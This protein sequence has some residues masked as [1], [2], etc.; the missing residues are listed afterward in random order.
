VPRR[1]RRA[2]QALTLASILIAGV[3]CAPEPRRVASGPGPELRWYRALAVEAAGGDTPAMLA[4]PGGGLWVA[5]PGLPDPGGRSRLFHR[6][7]GGAFR[8]L[9]EG[10]FATELSLSSV[11]AGEVYF[12]SNRPLEAFRPTL[13]RVS[14]EGVTALPAP[15]ERLDALEFLQIGGYAMRSASDGMACGQRGR[16]FRFTGEGWSPTTGGLPWAPGDPAARSFCRSIQRDA[17]GHGLLVDG[18][19]QGAAWD[20]AAFQPVP[21]SEGF[22]FLEPASGIA[23]RGASLS[24]FEGGAFV[25]LDGEVPAG[26]PLIGDPTGR[27]VAHPGGVLEVGPRA[28]R[29]LPG[30]LPFSPRALAEADG[31]LWALGADGVYRATRRD[32]PTFA[33]AGPEAPAPGLLYALAVDLDQD[34]DEDLLGLRAPAGESQGARASLVVALNDGAG[35]FVEASLGLPDD[36][37]L[38]GDRFDAGDVDGDGD[39]DVVTVSSGGRVELWLQDGGRF[40]RAWW[41]DAPGATV[42]LADVDGDGDLDLSLLPATPGLWLNDGAGHFSE[43]PPLPLPAAPVERALWADVDGDGAVDAVLQHWR[44][45]AHLLHNTGHGFEL[46]PLPVV[47]EGALVADLDREGRPAILAQKIHV[48]GV[49]LPFARCRCAAEGCVAVDG[50]PVPA[51]VVVDL[52]LDGRPD[53]IVTDLRGDEA[54]ASDGEVYLAGDDGYERVTDVAG[55]MPR[56]TPIDADGDGDPDVYSPALGLRLNTGAAPRFLRVRPRTS[57]SDRLARG[58][59]AVARR[60]GSAVLVSSG[61]ADH[62]VVTLGLPEADARYDLEVRFPAG[63][64]RTVTGL[65]AGTELTVRDHEGAVFAGRL[66]LLWV[67][68]TWLRA[69]P[70]RDL[71]VPVA[72]ALI[73]AA[74]P[75]RK[76]RRG[77]VLLGFG[78]AWLSLAGTFLRAPGAAPWLLTPAAVVLT[79]AGQALLAL[80]ARRR[81]VRVAGPYRLEERL[82]AGAAATVWRARAGRQVVA[83]KLFTAEAME[84]PEA[85]ERFFREARVGS[86]I[87]HPNVVRIREAGALEDGRCFLAM[88]LVPGRSLAERIRAEGPLPAAVVRAL[89]VDVARGLGALHGADIVHRDVKPENILVRPDGVAVLSDLGLARSSLFRTLTRHDVA[90]GTLSYMSPEQCVGRPLDGRSD[91][92]SLGVT[93]YQALTGRRAFDGKHELE[94]VYLV[95]NVDPPRPSAVVPGVPPALEAAILRCLSREPGDRFATARDL[96]AALEA[97]A[98]PSDPVDHA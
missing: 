85:R 75:P 21:R 1:S 9:Y 6:P 90:V 80:R 25:P 33:A 3:G 26:A 84:S 92:W 22:A 53:V 91:L 8:T 5:V 17:E 42:A 55:A 48:R 28:A 57:R 47:A 7:P 83:L 89:G 19:G 35:R 18:A 67:R 43:G 82:G 94:L 39:V 15:E 46:L 52:N 76:R 34:G 97:S 2:G 27:W 96:E 86:E 74:V 65:A 41:R 98:A 73:F 81:A 93:L 36:V 32:V 72:A 14:A 62:G 11:R 16:L 95:H 71:L 30:G 4:D 64:R 13:L 29:P 63:E 49:A 88:E 37:A 61:R 77:A 58:A 23:R 44:D 24:R 59:F 50:A 51:G 10:P 70:V 56:P 54:M 20:G 12:G 38:W 60:A 78:A 68:G 40:R 31:A 45:P 69:R 87:R 66:A 79:G